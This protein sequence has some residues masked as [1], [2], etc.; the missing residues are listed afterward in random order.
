MAKNKLKSYGRFE[1]LELIYNMRR[2]NQEL[3]QRCHELQK[4]MEEL[5][6]EYEHHIEELRMQGAAKDLQVR[7]KKIE[8]QVH[9]LSQL[10]SLEVD[11]SDIQVPEELLQEVEQNR[12][13]Q[14]QQQQ[15]PDREEEQ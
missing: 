7:M 4:R 13:I 9:L 1:L 15:Q 5:R 14:Q 12:Q 8:E 2:E 6:T 10:T 11:L 3:T